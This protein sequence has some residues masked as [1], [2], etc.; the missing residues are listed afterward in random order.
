M[1]HQRRSVGGYRFL[2]NHDLFHAIHSR[3]IEHRVQ[4]YIFHN[5][6]Q[7]ARASLPVDRAFGDGRQ[8]VI[9]ERKL[10]VLEFEQALVLFDQR[11]LRLSQ[12]CD[13]RVFIQVFQCRNDG[14][15]TNEFRDQ[16]KFQQILRFKV[17]EILSD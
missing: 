6:P 9:R 14:Q 7:A 8:G 2:V 4:Q 15:S 16:A 12:D 3:Q 1:D 13:Q 5:R 10:G 11:V 17:F